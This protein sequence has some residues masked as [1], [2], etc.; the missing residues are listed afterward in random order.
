MPYFTNKTANEQNATP[1]V[2]ET[3]KI[4][5]LQITPGLVL[6]NVCEGWNHAFVNMVGHHHDSQAR[7]NCTY[8][9]HK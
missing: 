7:Y 8:D 9:Y 1:T 4:I 3:Q 2:V 5:T 6:T